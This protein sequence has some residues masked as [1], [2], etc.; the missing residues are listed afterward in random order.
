MAAQSTLA[1]IKPDATQKGYTGAILQRITTAGFSIRAL[2]MKRMTQ[3]EAQQFY[4]LHSEQP[5]FGELVDFMTS[6]PIVAVVLQ[7]ENAVEDFRTLIGATNPEEAAE[8][9]LRKDYAESVGRNAIHGSDSNENAG[10]EIDFHFKPE[11]RF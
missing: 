9:T 4:Y 2:K 3:R 8:G 10:I 6:G 7:K 1:I 11:E 5:F